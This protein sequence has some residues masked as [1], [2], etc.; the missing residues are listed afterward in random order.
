[1]SDAR[2]YNFTNFARSTLL[3]AITADQTEVRVQAEAGN[4]FPAASVVDE[5]IFTL[6]VGA[7]GDAFEI[8][9]ATAKSADV[10]TVERAKEGSSAI[11]WPAG[12]AIVHTVTAGFYEKL[13]GVDPDPTATDI[14]LEWWQTSFNGGGGA[15]GA[16]MGLEFYDV[17]GVLL[18]SAFA[19]MEVADPLQ[20]NRRT[21]DAQAPIGTTTVRV[22]MEMERNQGTNNDGYIDDISMTVDGVSATL[23]NPGA[24][25]GSTSGWTVV[26]GVGIRGLPSPPAARTGNWYFYGGTEPASSAYQDVGI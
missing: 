2:Q 14:H 24:E 11:A 15:D 13:A 17:G 5:E 3:E 18:D 4:R 16:R 20:W 23:A 9:Y 1:M 12:T 22:I 21:L 8:M 6:V 26:A 25:A 7:S 19:L 10:F